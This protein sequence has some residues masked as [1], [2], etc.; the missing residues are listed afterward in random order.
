MLKRNAWYD[1]YPCKHTPLFKLCG[2]ESVLLPFASDHTASTIADKWTFL[3]T[4]Y[5][6]NFIN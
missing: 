2:I 6:G 3:L 5:F 1:V 4:K